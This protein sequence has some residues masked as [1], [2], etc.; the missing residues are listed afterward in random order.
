[1]ENVEPLSPMAPALKMPPPSKAALPETVQP[2]SVSVPWLRMPP[3]KR[4]QEATDEADAT[5]LPLLI[6]RPLR[7]T[8][9]F[10]ATSNT[11]DG[12]GDFPRVAGLL[13]LMVSWPAPGP[14]IVRFLVRPSSPL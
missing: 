10:W 14:W 12:G 8:M 1:M 4:S 3:P 2:L 5:P 11:R 6:V 7:V 13:P 9:V